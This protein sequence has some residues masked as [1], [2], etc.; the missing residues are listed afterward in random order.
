MVV[1]PSI[2]VG[3]GEEVSV[4]RSMLFKEGFVVEEEVG[5]VDEPD[6]VFLGRLRENATFFFVTEGG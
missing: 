4:V 3:D 6:L 1:S 2:L 5:L